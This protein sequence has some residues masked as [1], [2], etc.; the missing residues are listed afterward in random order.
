[1][2]YGYYDYGKPKTQETKV[3]RSGGL[4]FGSVLTIVFVVLKLCGVINWNWFWVLSPLIFSIGLFILILLILF[5][6]GVILA[7]NDR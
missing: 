5:V 4:G 7:L 6:V 1:M 2:K 3:V